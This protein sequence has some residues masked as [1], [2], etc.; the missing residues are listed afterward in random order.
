MWRNYLLVGI[1]ALLKNRVYA[2]I[3]IAGL[4]IG[5]AACLLILTYVRYEFSYD[6]WLPNA[7][8]SYELATEYLPR[9]VIASAGVPGIADALRM[10]HRPSSIAEAM[11]DLLSGALPLGEAVMRLMSRKLTV[12]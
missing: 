9:D 12:E 4:A 3:N 11:A 2:V 7:E 10:V 8:N 5:L 6:N 1:R